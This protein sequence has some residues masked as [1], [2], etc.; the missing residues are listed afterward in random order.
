MTYA[1]GPFPNI[2]A[3]EMRKCRKC[4]KKFEVKKK[5]NWTCKKCR[6][7]EVIVK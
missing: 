2:I 7:K 3:K 5:F 1:R 4:T 6:D